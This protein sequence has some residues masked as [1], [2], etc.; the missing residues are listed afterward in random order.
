MKC[1]SRMREGLFAR[2]DTAASVEVAVARGHVNIAGLR[3]SRCS[4][5]GLSARYFTSGTVIIL[6]YTAYGLFKPLV[7][8]F[9]RLKEYCRANS[10]FSRVPSRQTPANIITLRKLQNSTEHGRQEIS[11]RGGGGNYDE[12]GEL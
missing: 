4:S 5:P 6:N 11:S 7:L 10:I 1:S 2:V 3:T 9:L 12:G 8:V